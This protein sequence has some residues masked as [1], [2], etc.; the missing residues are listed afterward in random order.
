MATVRFEVD[1]SWANSTLTIV[2]LRDGA[3]LGTGSGTISAVA[4][5]YV[6]SGTIDL[7]A[8]GAGKVGLRLRDASGF[9]AALN[10]VYCDSSGNI[11]TEVPDKQSITIDLADQ[12]KQQFSFA[13]ANATFSTKTIEWEGQAATVVTGAIAF[14]KTVGSRSYYDWTYDAADRPTAAS[15]GLLIVSNGT[16]AESIE[17]DFQKPASRDLQEADQI[18]EDVAGI[19][20][21]KTYKKGTS[22]ELMTA[23]TAKQPGGGDLTTPTTQLLAGYRE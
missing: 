2:A 5:V 23:K 4:G 15:R 9:L 3:S 11:T 17:I 18:L 10:D 22:T 1:A 19:Q 16:L 20:K 12:G 8:A 21:L 14:R 7:S 6:W 13:I